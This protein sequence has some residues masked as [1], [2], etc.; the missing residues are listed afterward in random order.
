[1][2]VLLC[3]VMGRRWVLAVVVACLSCHEEQPLTFARPSEG[4]VAHALAGRRY[5]VRYGLHPEICDECPVDAY[6]SSFALPAEGPF[7][8]EVVLT[9]SD[10]HLRLVTSADDATRR[11]ACVDVAPL[12]LRSAPGKRFVLLDVQPLDH[13][14]PMPLVIDAVTGE[15]LA[16]DPE[17]LLDEYNR[18]CDSRF[19]VRRLWD[20]NLRRWQTR[21]R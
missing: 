7:E 14:P 16:Y 9:V 2:R 21:T 13:N 11:I 15:R 5:R 20:D 18:P 10:V 17:R 19:L 4:D 8:E 12:P 1:M 3:G 6:S